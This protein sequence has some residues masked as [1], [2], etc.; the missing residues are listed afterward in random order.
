MVVSRSGQAGLQTQWDC[1]IAGHR[2]QTLQETGRRGD[3]QKG[4][5]AEGETGRRKNKRKTYERQAVRE[6]TLR[7]TGS[8]R[9]K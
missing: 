2:T 3:R 6:I 8:K 5:Q 7:E 9:D 4:R 1:M